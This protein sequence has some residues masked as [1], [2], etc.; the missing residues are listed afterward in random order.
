MFI[1]TLYIL[2]NLFL[3]QQGEEIYD[4]K[5]EF[6]FSFFFKK[7]R[8]NGGCFYELF[9][10]NWQNMISQQSQIWQIFQVAILAAMDIF[11]PKFKWGCSALYG[12]NM[13]KFLAY[14][15]RF[16][17]TKIGDDQ[18]MATPDPFYPPKKLK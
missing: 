1:T 2:I 18:K 9:E 5:N 17:W 14:L 12:P 11:Y 6:Y 4:Y 8:K 13:F 15:L 3:N 10:Y 7:V 16:S